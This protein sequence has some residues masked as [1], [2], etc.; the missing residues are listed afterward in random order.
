MI[1]KFIGAMLLVVGTSIGAAMLAL[2][3]VV[4]GSG[5]VNSLGWFFLCWSC[6]TFG[7][8]YIL[9][10]NL[11]HPEDSNLIS[12]AKNTLGRGFGILTWVIYLLLLYTLLSAYISAISDILFDIM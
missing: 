4:A 1:Y 8:F 3:T 7:A 9:E 10:V 11:L 12:M 6:M 5:F 2:P